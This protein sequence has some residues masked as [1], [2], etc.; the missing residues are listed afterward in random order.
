MKLILC[1]LSLLWFQTIAA[2][3][4]TLP[5]DR[6]EPGEAANLFSLELGKAEE[7]FTALKADIAR[8]RSR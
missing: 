6:R 7:L 8:G 1:F 3:D 5:G 2:A 4:L